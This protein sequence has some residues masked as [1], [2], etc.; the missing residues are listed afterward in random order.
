MQNV[1][2]MS[3]G[4][5]ALTAVALVFSIFLVKPSPY[6]LL[7]EVDAPLD[8]ANIQKFNNVIQKFSKESQFIVITHNKST[9]AAVDVMYG[10]Y[11][12]EQGVS[13]VIPVDFRNYEHKPV[14]MS[15]LLN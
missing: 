11:M 2:L 6:C 12:A 1:S 4:E 7:D 15:T 14:E 9:M 13:D 5:K 10:V 3:G 8:D